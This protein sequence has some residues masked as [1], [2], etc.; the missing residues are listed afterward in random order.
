MAAEKEL[1][2][3]FGIDN[4][5]FEGLAEDLNVLKEG[6]GNAALLAISV[7]LQGDRNESE[8]TA[9]L[10]ALSVDLGD[11]GQ[12]DNAKQRAQIADWAMKTD[13]NGGLPKIRANVEGWK[14]AESAAPAFEQ[15]VT[16]FWMNE[17]G[18]D[19]CSSD[20][21]GALFAVKNKNSTY[22]A[23][24]DSAYTDGDSSLVRLICAASGDSFAWR[25]ATDIEKDVAAL[26]AAENGT[27]KRGSIDT[28]NVYVREN[29]SWRR[30]TELDATLG[31]AC[32]EPNRGMTDS[33]VVKHE[34]V[35][36]ICDVNDDASALP[37]IP[38]AWR[39]ATNAEADT[40]GF[41]AP[42]GEVARTGNKDESH[43]Y[44][45][46]DTSGNGDYAWRRGTNLDIVS[47]LG[48]CT[49]NRLD[50]VVKLPITN[51]SS[52]WYTCAVNKIIYENG[53][54][55]PYAWREATDI[56]KDTVGWGK[57]IITGQIK[58]GKVNT[59]LVY[60]YENGN[61]RHGTALDRYLGACTENK[62]AR[63]DTSTSN[64]KN[65]YYVC[66]PQST[67]DTLRKWVVAP[68][69][70]N[71]TI[72]SQAECKAFGKYGDGTILV[73]RVNQQ[74]KYVCEN[75]VFRAANSEE[76]SA[77]RACVGYIQNHI[78]KVNG[79]FSKCVNKQ[80]TRPNGRLMGT[81]KTSDGQEYRTV[82][83]G[84]LHWLQQNLNRMTGADSGDSIIVSPY[85]RPDTVLYSYSSSCYD[86]K[87]ANC[88]K[89]GRLYTR[90][91]AMRICP[92]GWHLPTKAEWMNLLFEADADYDS[93]LSYRL[94]ATTTWTF[95][96]TVS[97]DRKDV[98]SFSALG[99]GGFW[100]GS[101]TAIGDQT[102]Y[103]L[104]S[105]SSIMVITGHWYFTK[106]STTSKY[107]QFPVRCIQD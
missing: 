54:V 48:P 10:A 55:L 1:F 106:G 94:R 57:G 58:L 46:E 84:E 49:K 26:G 68:D 16:N 43:I 104:P 11:N 53:V 95:T 101:F 97:D 5:G 36:Y 14:L 25:F 105:E 71:D 41:G 29:D 32:V 102:Y 40:A 6:K 74:N 93:T 87:Q 80:W 61:W 77:N 17:L 13:L 21:E 22:Y 7:L 39:K 20:N 65:E 28:T 15:H 33:L 19:T 67:P 76:I 38:T 78:Y 89:Y 12:W 24:N 50:T 4:S 44:V 52:A 100:S 34:P 30:G 66:T 62:A 18:V 92:T 56:E 69:I 70:Y 42:D 59:N 82:V 99:S 86:H 64:Y 37:S 103:W 85:K 51:N 31:A 9:L 27:V 45:H 35:W 91:A 47:D 107:N 72:G 63:R 79:V 90:E 98:V 83:I 60:V 75:G 3:A 8:L 96:S 23:A 88:D 2:T 81:L 73:G